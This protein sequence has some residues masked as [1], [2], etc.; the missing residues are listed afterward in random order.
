[1][2]LFTEEELKKSFEKAVKE[3]GERLKIDFDKIPFNEFLKGVEVEMEHKDLAPTKDLTGKRD[4]EFFAKIALVHLKESPKYYVEL[5]KM[6]K[7]LKKETVVKTIKTFVKEDVNFK[8]KLKFE[9]SKD[10]KN[11]QKKY[12]ETLGKYKCDSPDQLTEE[13]RSKF[14]EELE[15]VLNT[16][17]SRENLADN[18]T[19]KLPFQDKGDLKYKDE[20]AFS[21][22]LSIGNID[23]NTDSGMSSGSSNRSRTENA[24]GQ[25]YPVQEVDINRHYL[26]DHGG[27]AE[28]D[29]DKY[30]LE[31]V[32]EEDDLKEV[33]GDDDNTIDF[34]TMDTDY[35]KEAALLGTADIEI[36]DKK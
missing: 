33:S 27:I 6:E 20:A 26:D 31:I 10:D 11:Y 32:D 35:Q 7:K 14:F 23:N 15:G 36:K 9:L 4:V 28:D 19:D 2:P 12:N 8:H 13:E 25:P 5:D 29:M 22:G 1:M 24:Y 18:P 3:V 21:L 30:E 16:E 17:S 34:K